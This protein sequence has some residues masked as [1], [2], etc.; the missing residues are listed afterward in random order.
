[1]F[2]PKEG[3]SIL[4]VGCGTGAFLQFYQ[5]YKCNL[6]GIDMSPAMLD[7]ARS[8]LGDAADLHLGSAA[9]MPYPDSAF[10]LV[11]S[12]LVLHEIDHPLRL[13]VLNEIKRVLKP[14]GRVL[15]I[16]F[17]PGRPESI[18][19]W[20]T[21]AVILL[22]EIAA[23]R[24][25]FRNYR[26]FMSINGLPYLTKTAG[27]SSVKQKTVAGGPITLILLENKAIHWG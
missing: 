22:S 13:E 24:K 8:R 11:V 15:L 23:G 16:D 17:N 19:G 12:M 14:T 5:R 1:M 20:R 18:E 6:Y 27:F 25:H 7:L 9:D 2:L 4:D 10:D 21:K 3:M 26:H